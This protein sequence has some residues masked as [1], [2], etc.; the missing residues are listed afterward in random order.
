[1]HGEIRY[2]DVFHF[3]RRLQ[4]FERVG[5]SFQVGKRIQLVQ[6]KHVEVIRLQVAQ[7]IFHR[8]RDV[9]RGAI[10]VVHAVFRRQVNATFGKKHDIRTLKRLLGKHF[11]KAFFTRVIAITIRMVKRI[12]A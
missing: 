2:A 4:F 12:N 3:T 8:L 7:R 5:G 9:C 10:N 1:M 11:A 6:Q